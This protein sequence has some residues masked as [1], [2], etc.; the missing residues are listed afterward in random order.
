MSIS[1]M[2]IS[3]F[4]TALGLM[5]G[6][7][8]A[9]IGPETSATAHVVSQIADEIHIPMLSFGATD[10][11]L[12][13]LQYPFFVRT[14]QNDL[15]QM[16]AIA[17][18]I[19]YYGWRDVTA[20]YVD[21]DHGRNGI[22]ALGDKLAERRCRISHK[23]PISPSLSRENIRNELKTANSE[24]SRIF[25]LLAYADWGL[26]VF[27]VAQDNGMTGSGY[28]WLVTDWLASTFDTNSSISPEAIG[29]VQGAITLR[30]HTPDSQQKTKFVSGWSKLITRD[31]MVNGTGL[32]TYGLYAYDTVWL[33]AYGIDA[34]FKQGGNIS[35]SQDPKVTEQHRGKLKVD[36][37]RIFN[38]GDLLLHII[39]Q[40]NTTGVAGPIKFDSDR[41]LIHPAY[42]VMNVN[43]KGFKRIGYWSNY[44]GLSVVPPETLYTKPPNRSS[45]S[46]ELESVIWPGQTKQ[47][48]RGWVFP[49]NGRQLR[50]AVPNHV[51][52]HELVSVKG[53]DSFSGYCIDVFTAA[54]SSLPYAVP[55]KLHA[56]GDGINKP[57]ISELLQLIEAGVSI[58]KKKKKIY[59]FNLTEKAAIFLSEPLSILFYLGL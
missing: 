6:E 10:P 52:Y 14:T 45:L 59:S 26:E 41:N 36:E 35:F 57:K 21:D 25:V 17:E 4:P 33:L 53:A 38:G 30:M 42:E 54:L 16:A 56:F 20:I 46:Q 58:K 55:Y 47:K 34:F 13:S 7:T 1:L 23:A 40:V 27:S 18:I 43:G 22:A 50:I 19:D 37:V 12:S 3:L 48:P 28:V 44:S 51:I 39:L 49:E 31:K 9:I 2:I 11:T 5:D 24:E 29:G 32:N 8:V 15:F